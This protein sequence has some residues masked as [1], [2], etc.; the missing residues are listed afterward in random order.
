M[1]YNRD[2]DEA[3]GKKLT[4]YGDDCKHEN[5]TW[6]H[7]REHYA[8]IFFVCPDCRKEIWVNELKKLGYKLIKV[9]SD[10]QT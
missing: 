9:E 3:M 4:V 8:D 1:S 7:L 2:T 6:G 10:E 5:I